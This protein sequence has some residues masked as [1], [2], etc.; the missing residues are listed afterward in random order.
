[1]LFR[2]ETEKRRGRES[3]FDLGALCFGL[4]NKTTNEGGGEK[5]NCS[6]II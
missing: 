1:M 2:G 5:K 4:L 6:G 3:A